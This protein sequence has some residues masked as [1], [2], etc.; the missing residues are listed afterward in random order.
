MLFFLLCAKQNSV[1]Q[2]GQTQNG[3]E[4]F[5]RPSI[6]SIIK[7][8]LYGVTAA[9]TVGYVG[10]TFGF[11]ELWYKDYPRS[12]FHFFDDSQEW[13]QMDKVG[14][15]CTAYYQSRIAGDVY[16]WT[17]IK[18]RKAALLGAGTGMLL[19]TT[20]E[21]LDG[22]SAEWGFSPT[23]ELAN[24][25]GCSLYLSQ[26]LAWREQRI[27]FKIS[28]H[29]RPS[30]LKDVKLTSVNNP[31]ATTTL[32]A[33]AAALYGTAPQEILIK[34]Y[35]TMTMWTSVNIW[36]FL[37]NR[38]TSR[39]PTWLNVAVGYGAEN[40]YRGENAYD[41]TDKQ[42]NRFE[43]N[44]LEYPRYRQVFLAPD[45]DFTKIKTKSHLLKFVFKGLSVFKFPMPTLEYNTTGKFV[46][47]P[48]YF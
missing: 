15:L 6:D 34:D 39:F 23:D 26:E 28:S 9:A 40:L 33:R 2:N 36:S 1:A 12:N 46:F 24:L 31:L 16:Q 8:R 29:G 11:N 27:S 25:G 14:H 37:P 5:L 44:S 38:E 17:G 21:M 4:R 45:I 18:H 30:S 35:N 48:I 32:E 10:L 47:H 43:L 22:F 19:Q 3:L 13:N 42:G 41:W 20:L 7:P